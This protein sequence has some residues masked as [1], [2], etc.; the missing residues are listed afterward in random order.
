MSSREYANGDVFEGDFDADGREHGVGRL[1]RADGSAFVGQF[2]RG[3]P[4]GYG[5]FFVA[6]ASRFGSLFLCWL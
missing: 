1:L 5:A 3:A 4:H 2:A 6:V